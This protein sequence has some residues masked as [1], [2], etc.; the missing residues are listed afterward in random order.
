MYP[1][2]IQEKS[3][4]IFSWAKEYEKA[5]VM[6]KLWWQSGNPAMAGLTGDGAIRRCQIA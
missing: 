5:P 3:L 1:T 6:E 4:A 2:P